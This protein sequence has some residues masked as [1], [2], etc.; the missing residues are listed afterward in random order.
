MAAAVSL[1]FPTWIVAGQMAGTVLIRHLQP[2]KS[3]DL[4]ASMF[5]RLELLRQTL[6]HLEC[7]SPP[8]P[9]PLNSRHGEHLSE[10]SE[11]GGEE[12]G[13]AMR[14]CSHS[15]SQFKQRWGGGEGRRSAESCCNAAD[16][17]MKKS[18]LGSWYWTLASDMLGVTLRNAAQCIRRA[19]GR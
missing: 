12:K 7:L 8:R 17:S 6:S 15:P 3:L 16:Q 9:S 10:S 13:V 18:C 4:L 1:T 14:E 2:N 5:Y 11:G 19:V